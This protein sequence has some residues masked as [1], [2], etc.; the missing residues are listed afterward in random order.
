MRPTTIAIASPDP[1]TSGWLRWLSLVG[2]CMVVSLGFDWP[3]SLLL[4][5]QLGWLDDAGNVR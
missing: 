5:A 1:T 3:G 4:A 2:L